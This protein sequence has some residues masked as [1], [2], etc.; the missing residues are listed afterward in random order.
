MTINPFSPIE[1][2][3]V[4]VSKNSLK[5]D[6]YF[7]CVMNSIACILCR[8]SFHLSCNVKSAQ[9]ATSKVKRFYKSVSVKKST[10]ESQ[11]NGLGLHQSYQ[12]FLDSRCL[13][14]PGGRELRLMNEPVAL[15]IANEWM[16]QKEF[17][18][19]TGMHFTSLANT[20]IDNPL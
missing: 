11:Q 10:A 12:V 9:P 4:T 7:R 20:C 16:S 18:L 3:V 2:C 17:L 5:S 14:T 1:Y 19:P 8:R 15:S 6:N 13:K